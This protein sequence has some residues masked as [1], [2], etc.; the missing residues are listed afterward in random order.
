MA[1]DFFNPRDWY[2]FV[3]ADE[4][5]VY[6]SK[7]DRLVPVA[8]ATYA[9]WVAEGGQTSRAANKA[10]MGEILSSYNLRP[11][12]ASMLDGYTEKQATKLTLEVVAKALFNV[13]NR[14]RIL[15]GNQ[16]V[17]AAQFKAYL[18]GLM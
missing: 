5:R 16:P 4:T 12:D 3:G 13:V 6:S 14:V 7:A 17:T 2:W 8:D 9:A 11:S 15:E 18:K 10:E 1:V